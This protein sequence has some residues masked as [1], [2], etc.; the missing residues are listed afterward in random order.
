M[1]K[2]ENLLNSILCCSG[3]PQGKTET[4]RKE[5]YKY[6]GLARDQPKVDERRTSTNGPENKKTNDDALGFTFQR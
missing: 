5:R 2:K 6:L 4:K 3:W 1:N